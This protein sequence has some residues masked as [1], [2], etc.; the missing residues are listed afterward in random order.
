MAG[1]VTDVHSMGGLCRFFFF[2][3]TATTE[4]YTL[5]L[6]DALPIFELLRRDHPA[7]VQRHG[8]PQ[9]VRR[10]L[11]VRDGG[12]DFRGALGRRLCLRASLA[13]QRLE[14]R[15]LEHR[16]RVAARSEERRVGKECR[17]RWSPY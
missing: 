17:S 5:S 9:V 15:L 1:R 8:A 7:L 14:P 2:N 16:D 13:D 11:A 12:G 6:H 4:I 3:D 10:A